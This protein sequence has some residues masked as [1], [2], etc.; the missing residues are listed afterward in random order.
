M[1]AWCQ[2]TDKPVVDVVSRY[3][4]WLGNA[5]TYSGVERVDGGQVVAI[6]NAPKSSR[7]LAAQWEAVAARNQA[8][9]DEI[10]RRSEAG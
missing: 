9:Q 8:K 1:A 6:G 2:S 7:D 4:R 3:Q 5:S 10:A